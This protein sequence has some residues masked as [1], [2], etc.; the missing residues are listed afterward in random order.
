MSDVTTRAQQWQR[1]K[2]ILA[3]ALELESPKE[4]TAFLVGSCDGDTALMHEVEALL[5][6]STAKLDE[7][8]DSTPMA[9]ARSAPAQP[10]GRRIGAYEIVREIG[11]GGM[12]AVY[13]AKRADG[14]FEKE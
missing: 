11:R 2:T 1:V 5:A 7:L 6:Q 10:S 13:L 8:A 4:R 9:F 3:D 14:Q 12:G